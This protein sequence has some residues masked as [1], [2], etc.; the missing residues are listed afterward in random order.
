[1]IPGA[2]VETTR[3]QLAEMMTNPSPEVRRAALLTLSLDHLGPYADLLVA[4]LQE[5]SDVSVLDA[6]KDVVARYQWEPVSSGALRELRQWAA[7]R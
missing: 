4:R 5:E 3:Q 7:K 1:V 6:M 2:E